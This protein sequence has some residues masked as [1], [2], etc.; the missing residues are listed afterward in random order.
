GDR[1]SVYQRLRAGLTRTREKLYLGLGRTVGPKPDWDAI[2]ESLLEADVGVSA[3]TSIMDELRSRRDTDTRRAVAEKLLTILTRP[4]SS[5]TTAAPRSAR[6]KVVLVV[7]VNGV[8]KTT[9]AA[10]L[11]HRSIR[12]GLKTLIVAADTFRAAALE[13]MESWARRAGAELVRGREGADPASVVHDGLHAAR[14]RSLDEVIIDTAGRLHTKRPLMDE[15]AKVKRIAGRQVAGAPQRTLLVMD[16]TVGGNGLVQ[17]REFQES[18]GV[19]GI[20]LAKLDGTA[21]GGIAVAVAT[22]LGLP[23]HFAGVGEGLEDLVPF[24]PEDFV[25]ALLGEDSGS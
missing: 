4:A 16:A 21:K 25:E 1:D 19:D 11:A 5:E 22:E 7:G 14:A 15:L 2:E 24:S 23:V 12:A 9:T 13:Q 20:V 8:G 10:K 6:P 18:I 3:A 17:A